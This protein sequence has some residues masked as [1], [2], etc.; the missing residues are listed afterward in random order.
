MSKHPCLPE[1]PEQYPW[2]CP[3]APLDHCHGKIFWLESGW[4]NLGTRGTMLKIFNIICNWFLL[5][6]LLIG[7]NLVTITDICSCY[8][9]IEQLMNYQKSLENI[10][11][12]SILLWSVRKWPII[13]FCLLGQWPLFQKGRVYLPTI[14][15]R[16]RTKVPMSRT[17]PSAV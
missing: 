5:I 16:G 12:L 7:H 9:W 13:H 2:L 11:G 8:P 3:W 14:T 17:S 4:C 6:L 10:M 1:P 15:R